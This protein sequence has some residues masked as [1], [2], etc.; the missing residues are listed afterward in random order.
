MNVNRV[1]DVCFALTMVCMF[2]ILINIAIYEVDVY[3]CSNMCAD[4]KYVMEKLGLDVCYVIDMDERHAYLCI[5]TFGMN[6][7]A[8][9]LTPRFSSSSGQ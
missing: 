9:A 3:D 4:Q 7:E 8:T 1:V 2:A 6:W 5:R